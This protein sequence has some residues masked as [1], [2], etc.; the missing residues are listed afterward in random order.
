MSAPLA[1]ATDD[2]LGLYAMDA[3]GGDARRRLEQHVGDCDRCAGRLAA[4][5]AAELQLGDLW[6]EVRRLRQPL[7]PVVPLRPVGPAAPAP[8]AEPRPAASTGGGGLLVAAAA[9]LFVGWSAAP[10]RAVPASATLAPDAC[11]AARFSRADRPD[12]AAGLLCSGESRP[13][14]SDLASW[15]AC[16]SPRR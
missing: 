11:F 8:R 10:H 3:L 4:E 7:A 9:L 15:A 1:H 13:S 6:P 5:A 12:D 2:E 16:A 14:P